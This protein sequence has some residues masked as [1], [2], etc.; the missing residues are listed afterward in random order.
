MFLIFRDFGVSGVLLFSSFLLFGGFVCFVCF[1][2]G[3]WCLCLLV[4]VTLFL[5]LVFGVSAGGWLVCV[6]C[7]FA[8]VCA[9]WYLVFG[10]LWFLLV[11]GF[12]YFGVWILVLVILVLGAF[13]FRVVWYL[14][15]LL[16]GFRW[17]VV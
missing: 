5:I 1:G 16:A 2:F 4:G 3:S 7:G 11:G 10:V 6:F 14:V 12:G 8:L 15:L 17:F 9:F 13:C